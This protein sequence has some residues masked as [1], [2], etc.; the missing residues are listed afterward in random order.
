MSNYKK[1]V[2]VVVTT[3]DLAH[4]HYLCS[5]NRAALSYVRHLNS[6]LDNFYKSQI[7]DSG[8]K[9]IVVRVPLHSYQNFLDDQ[10]FVNDVF[11]KL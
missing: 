8:S 2:Y 6:M 3:N 7:L 10:S 4:F 1:F 11:K 9:F 5:S